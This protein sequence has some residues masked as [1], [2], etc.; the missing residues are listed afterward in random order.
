M[1]TDRQNNFL[2]RMINIKKSNKSLNY[3]EENA[4]ER[5]INAI[6]NENNFKKGINNFNLTIR[7]LKKKNKEINPE[8]L[9]LSEG[10]VNIYGEPGYKLYGVTSKGNRSVDSAHVLIN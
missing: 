7:E 4:I 2:Q 8:V 10:L 5:C 1:L 6:Q 3:K 9:K